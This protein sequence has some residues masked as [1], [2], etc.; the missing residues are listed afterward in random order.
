VAENHQ[1][2]NAL[3]LSNIGAAVIEQEKEMDYSAVAS[4]I[5]KLASDRERLLQMGNSA[6]KLSVTDSAHRIYQEVIGLV[7]E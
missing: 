1:Y 2:Y 4:R 3:S 7:K 6:K 5:L